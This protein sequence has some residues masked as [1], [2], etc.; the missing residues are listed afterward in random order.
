MGQIVNV[1]ASEFLFVADWSLGTW[2]DYRSLRGVFL[3]GM[4][5]RMLDMSVAI[6]V[7]LTW[8]ALQACRVLTTSPAVPKVND[9]LR[10][11]SM[12]SMIRFL[13]F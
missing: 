12:L 5:L 6:K 1:E 4:L 11:A 7:G 3:Y 8:S 9:D 2:R 10:R 13:S